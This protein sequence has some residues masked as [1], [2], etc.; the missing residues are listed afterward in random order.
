MRAKTKEENQ[1]ISNNKKIITH[2]KQIKLNMMD[3]GVKSVFDGVLFSP[4]S[5]RQDIKKEYVYLFRILE[6][7]LANMRERATN[8]N[9]QIIKKCVN[10]SDPETINKFLGNNY[11]IIGGAKWIK[12]NP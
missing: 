8:E 12:K 3:G 5:Y 10:D 9:K 1:T 11:I 6:G 2:C 7:K 4:P